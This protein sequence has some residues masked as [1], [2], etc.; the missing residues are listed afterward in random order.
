MAYKEGSI[1]GEGLRNRHLACLPHTIQPMS[2]ATNSTP[3][4]ANNTTITVLYDN[5]I[6]SIPQEGKQT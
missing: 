4:I 6:A 3:R 5:I 2:T 1:G